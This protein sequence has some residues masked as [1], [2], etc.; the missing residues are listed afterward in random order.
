[1]SGQRPSSPNDRRAFEATIEDEPAAVDMRNLV[2]PRNG[3]PSK[4]HREK[5]QASGFHRLV[6][7]R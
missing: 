6:K 3:K 1:V 4:E 2:I 5:E 7:W